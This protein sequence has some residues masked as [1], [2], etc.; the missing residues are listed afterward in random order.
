MP[1]PVAHEII[2]VVDGQNPR[3]SKPLKEIIRV[4]RDV[5]DEGGKNGFVDYLSVMFT[6]IPYADWADEKPADFKAEVSK[7]KKALSD[8]WASNMTG[9]AH[10]DV[11]N[12]SPEAAERL[13]S[14]FMFVNNALPPKKLQQLQNDFELQPDLGESR[15][16]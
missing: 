16:P 6:K 11:L 5:F 14:R 7:K 1:C 13:K 10:K 2:L 8:S 3:L 15:S 9:L 12:L 4:L